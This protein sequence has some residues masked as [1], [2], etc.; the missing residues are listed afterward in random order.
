MMGFTESILLAI[1][2]G[3]VVSVIVLFIEY[4]YFHRRPSRENL[5]HIAGQHQLSHKSKEY[6]HSSRIVTSFRDLE[7]CWRQLRELRTYDDVSFAPTPKELEILASNIRKAQE[8]IEFL[9]HDLAHW[10]QSVKSNRPQ[11]LWSLGDLSTWKKK[12]NHE[13]SRRSYHDEYTK[14]DMELL[15]NTSALLSQYWLQILLL[16]DHLELS[17]EYKADLKQLW[18]NRIIAFVL[19]VLSYLIASILLGISR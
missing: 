8:L 13:M 9:V 6:I 15:E 12:I 10:I 2:E 1:C 7:E 18:I 4:N 17:G 16:I 5:M 3:V 19:G 14:E 11:R